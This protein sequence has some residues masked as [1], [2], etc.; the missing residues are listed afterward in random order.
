[1]AIEIAGGGWAARLLP[2]QGGAFASLAW[3]GREV[4]APLPSGADPNVNFAGAFVMAP[5]A[6]RLD[7]GLLPVAGTTYHLPV[8]RP[9][10]NT[11]IHG[12]LRDRPWRVEQAFAARCVLLQVLD[13]AALVAQA[14]PEAGRIPWRCTTRLTVALGEAGVQVT[15]SLTNDAALPLPCGFGWHPFFLRPA[16]TGLRFHATALFARDAR[17]LPIAVQPSDG[18]VGDEAAYEGLD[19][20]FAGWDG[21]AEIIR[22]DL[23]LQLS[24]TGAWAHNLQVFA[25]GGSNVLCLDAAGGDGLNAAG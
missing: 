24:A 3:Q 9:E 4:L 8:N 19:T 1:M 14:G 21:E 22:P 10:D 12:L 20:H 18:V 23:R 15:L 13:D 7:G 16:G 17:C 2:E 5:W 25:P 11:A 6:N